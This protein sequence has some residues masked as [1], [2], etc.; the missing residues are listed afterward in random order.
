[1]RWPLA[2]VVPLV[3]ASC[4]SAGSTSGDGRT[5]EVLA[6]ASLSGA[7]ERLATEFEN[8]HPG[9]E[10]RI[11]P[12]SSATLAQQVVEGAPADV[13]AT[14][15]ERTMRVAV[16]GGGVTTPERFAS[17]EMVLVTAA[18]N[19]AGIRS[20]EDLEDTDYVVC[21]ETAPCGAVAAALLERNQVGHPP[22]S[23]QADV[24]AVE[25]L[26]LADEV[27]AGL[28]YASDAAAEPDRL[29]SF[30]VPG[31]AEHRNPYLVAVT[32]Q[33]D[34]AELAAEWVDLLTGERGQDV[35]RDLGFRGAGP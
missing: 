13:L 27:D 34:D 19:P 32:E 8:T 26:V 4:G 22:R 14:A 21:V 1:V 10:V 33:S 3:L 12:G 6:A 23:Y 25:Q 35:L 9:V 5:L 18:G 17:N 24:K 28:V 20:V 16:D 7:F 29:R 2:C 30:P 31:S 11:N 15:D